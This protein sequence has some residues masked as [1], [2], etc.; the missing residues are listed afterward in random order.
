MYNS[1]VD[2]SSAHEARLNRYK[3]VKGGKMFEFEDWENDM[4]TD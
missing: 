2:E 3:E 4:T 1:R